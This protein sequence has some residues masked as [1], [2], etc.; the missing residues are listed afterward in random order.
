MKIATGKIYWS[1]RGRKQRVLA[2]IVGLDPLASWHV[3]RLF[4]PRACRWLPEQL[5]PAE[6]LT[7]RAKAADYRVRF[8]LTRADH[9]LKA[10]LA[11]AAPKKGRR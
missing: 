2:A 11:G 8:A 10:A 6:L 5:L 9:K 1:R 3:V 4:S 7:A